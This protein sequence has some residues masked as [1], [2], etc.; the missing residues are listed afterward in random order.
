M[1]FLFVALSI[2]FAT[3][4]SAEMDIK[5]RFLAGSISVSKNVKQGDVSGLAK[6]IGSKYFNPKL[7]LIIYVHG[8]THYCQSRG[9][10]P[11]LDAMTKFEKNTN[12][13]FVDYSAYTCAFKE[14]PT[15]LTNEIFDDVS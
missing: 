6:I 15:V 12:Y 7:K 10:K 11:V 5:Y 3:V 2:F 1:K 14:N 13:L 4:L 9:A 8:Y